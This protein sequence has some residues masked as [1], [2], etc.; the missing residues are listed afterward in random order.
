[1]QSKFPSKSP[2]WGGDGVEVRLLPVVNVSVWL[3]DLTQHLYAQSKSILWRYL[4]WCHTNGVLHQL[5]PS[6]EKLESVPM[7]YQVFDTTLPK[8]L[9]FVVFQ[10]SSTS[11]KENWGWWDLSFFFSFSSLKSQLIATSFPQ[12][13]LKF[14]AMCFICQ[15]KLISI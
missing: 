4:N 5:M 6:C 1:M 13:N 9:V 14:A 8:P 12:V 2:V 11:S 3:P 7:F 10:V 15:N